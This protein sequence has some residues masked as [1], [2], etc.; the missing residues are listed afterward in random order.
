MSPVRDGD[1][2]LSTLSR[3]E[4][5]QDRAVGQVGLKNRDGGKVG[6]GGRGEIS[7]ASS[8]SLPRPQCWRT[9]PLTRG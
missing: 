9:K 7:Y 4:A 1:T 2:R 8:A 3:P 6:I 5:A